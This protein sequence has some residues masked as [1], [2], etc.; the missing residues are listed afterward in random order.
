MVASQKSPLIKS[1]S[2]LNSK[3]EF[4]GSNKNLDLN[5]YTEIYEDLSKETSDRYEYIFPSYQW[6]NQFHLFEYNQPMLLH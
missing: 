1:Q 4:E 6:I 5:V 3:I 2:V